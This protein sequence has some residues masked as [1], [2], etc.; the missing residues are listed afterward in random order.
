[1]LRRD[2]ND[3]MQIPHTYRYQEYAAF[4][5]LNIS[6]DGLLLERLVQ[7]D[8]EEPCREEVMAVVEDAPLKGSGIDFGIGADTSSLRDDSTIIMAGTVYFSSRM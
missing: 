2:C 5:L 4:F 8:D 7:E 1:M 6:F 3:V